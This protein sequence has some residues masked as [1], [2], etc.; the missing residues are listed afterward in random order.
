MAILI[1]AQKML[2]LPDAKTFAPL[3]MRLALFDLASTYC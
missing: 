2:P 3:W 1:W